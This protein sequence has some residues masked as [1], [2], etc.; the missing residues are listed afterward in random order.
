[1]TSILPEILEP[2][3]MATKGRVGLLEGL[4]EVVQLLLHEE[5]GG[6]LLD[7]VGDALSGG[8]GAM[9]AAEGVVDVDVAE[10]GELLRELGIVG[11]F[12]GVE[13]EVFQQQD[14]AGF[15]LAGKFF[16][17][18]ADAVGGKGDVGLF[19]EVMIEQGAEAVDDGA[20]AVFEID[21]AF[22]AA[23]VGGEDELGL[24]AQRVLDGGQGLFDAGVVGDL[25]AVL[26][27][28]DVEVDAHEDVLVGEVEVANRKLCHTVSV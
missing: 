14:L 11:F 27:E 28:G 13:A 8:V 6:G 2:P 20:Q 18:V 9:G 16:G 10:G 15:K 24:V 4:A 21:L 26:G 1:M 25:G 22:G 19:A 23:E 7:E 5:A 17:D 3:R 12:F